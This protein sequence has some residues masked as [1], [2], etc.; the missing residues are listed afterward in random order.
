MVIERDASNHHRAYKHFVLAAK[1]GIKE[2]L[3]AVK[4]GYM[5]GFVTKEEYANTLR[6][7]QQRQ[8]EMKS[9]ER[10]KAEALRQISTES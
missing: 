1:A 10:D 6:A 4:K 2:S 3:N 5:K 8:D 7:Y 9:D